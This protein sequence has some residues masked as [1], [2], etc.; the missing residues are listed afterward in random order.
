MKSQDNYLLIKT[1]SLGGGGPD[2]RGPKSGL[3]PSKKETHEQ[4]IPTKSRVTG[5][6]YPHSMGDMAPGGGGGN[7]TTK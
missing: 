5:P 2:K 3:G 6:A 4:K 1:L 7:S